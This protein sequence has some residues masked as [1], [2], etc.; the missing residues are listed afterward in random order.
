MLIVGENVTMH[1][2]NMQFEKLSRREV[3]LTPVQLRLS[4]HS[5]INCIPTVCICCCTLNAF[6]RSTLA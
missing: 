1:N 5:Y 4:E 3:M 6:D 2:E